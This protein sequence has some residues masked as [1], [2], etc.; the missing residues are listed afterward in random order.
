MQI[1]QIIQILKLKKTKSTIAFK[2]L[3]PYILIIRK[4]NKRTLNNL[5]AFQNPKK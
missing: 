5:K 1:I 2:I 3:T 4:T